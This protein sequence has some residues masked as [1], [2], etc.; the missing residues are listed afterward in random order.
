M[1]TLKIDRSI[2]RRRIIIAVI[3]IIIIIAIIITIIIAIIIVAI[4]IIIMIAIIMIIGRRQGQGA[5]RQGPRRPSQASG[6]TIMI[7]SSFL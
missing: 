1:D 7:V 5:R 2:P 3:I 6:L 4:I